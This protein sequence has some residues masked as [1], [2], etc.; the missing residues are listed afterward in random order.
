[1]GL[2]LLGQHPQAVRAPQLEGGIALYS[3]HRTGATAA[4]SAGLILLQRPEEGG[5]SP[6]F[7]SDKKKTC[8]GNPRCM[9]T[10]VN[11]GEGG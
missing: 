1:M 9:V 7:P 5:Q 6:P 3:H 10:L 11:L 8:L 4:D 2:T